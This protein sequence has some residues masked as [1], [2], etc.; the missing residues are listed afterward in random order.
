MAELLASRNPA[1]TTE[2]KWTFIAQQLFERHGFDRTWGSIKMYWSR[3][4]RQASGIDER[5]I[6][7]PDVMVTGWYNPGARKRY[8]D[9]VKKAMEKGKKGVG[10]EK[11]K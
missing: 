1:C 5:R 7:K 10:S 2:A 6:K 4:G 9:R 8:R 3:Y 11:T